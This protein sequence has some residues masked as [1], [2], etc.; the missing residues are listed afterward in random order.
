M[1]NLTCDSSECTSSKKQC[2]TAREKVKKQILFEIVIGFITVIVFALCSSY[3]IGIKASDQAG[4]I[5]VFCL[6]VS[7]ISVLTFFN[8]ARYIFGRVSVLFSMQK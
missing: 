7:G 2:P 1:E 5:L 4:H 8:S 3:A 6:I